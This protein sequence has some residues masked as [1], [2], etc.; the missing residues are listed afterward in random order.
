MIAV[1]ASTLMVGVAMPAF[2]QGASDCPPGLAKKG[3]VPP[4]QARK[5]APAYVPP[6]VVVYQPPVTYA[7][8]YPDYRPS[9]GSVNIGVSVPLPAQP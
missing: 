8:A 2:A 3:C 9:G 4:G 1:L 6:P 5:M 7:P